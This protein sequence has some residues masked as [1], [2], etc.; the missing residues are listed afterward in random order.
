MA[1]TDLP[2]PAPTFPVRRTLARLA[3]RFGRPDTLPQDGDTEH[4]DFMLDMLDGSCTAVRSETD[5]H[6]M[7][8][9]Y[10]GRF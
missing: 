7:M 8:S 10:P 1:L 5:L 9:V 3:E 2:L 6:C 4:R